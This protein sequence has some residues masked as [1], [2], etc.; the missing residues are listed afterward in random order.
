MKYIIKCPICKVKLVYSKKPKLIEFNEQGKP[1]YR[2]I[3]IK[4]PICEFDIALIKAQ[5]FKTL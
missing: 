2:D 3:G 4:C 5:G 1:A